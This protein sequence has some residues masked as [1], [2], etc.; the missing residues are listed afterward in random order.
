MYS[1]VLILQKAFSIISMIYLIKHTIVLESY[2]TSK[3]NLLANVVKGCLWIKQWQTFW[4]GP[5]DTS[6]VCR[7]SFRDYLKLC[8]NVISSFLLSEAAVLKCSVKIEFF[9]FFR[10]SPLNKVA[11]LY[12]NLLLFFLR[13]QKMKIDLIIFTV[14]F[15]ILGV[16]FIL[17]TLLLILWDLV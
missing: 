6:E 4:H 15:V 5:N 14:V 12:Q 2:Q 11:P 17:L 1:A 9:K 8:L 7:L 3:M 16:S 10:K 13:C